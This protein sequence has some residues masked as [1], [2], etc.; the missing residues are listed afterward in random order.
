MIEEVLHQFLIAVVR[1]H[2]CHFEAIIQEQRHE[3]KLVNILHFRHPMS[4]TSKDRACLDPIKCWLDESIPSIAT[5][6]I[7]SEME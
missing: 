1:V 6:R 7:A 4:I 5:P 2:Q 3:M